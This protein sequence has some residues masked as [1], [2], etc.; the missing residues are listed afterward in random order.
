MLI[1]R[2]HAGRTEDWPVMSTHRSREVPERPDMEEQMRSTVDRN[3]KV[4]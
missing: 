1:N 2:Q 3:K 4:L